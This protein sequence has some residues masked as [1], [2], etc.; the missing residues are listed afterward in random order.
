MFKNFSFF[1]LVILA[2]GIVGYRWVKN[3]TPEKIFQS[4]FCK[5]KLKNSL[6]TMGRNNENHSKFLG[7][8]KPVTYLMLFENNTEL[9]RAGI[10]WQL[11]GCAGG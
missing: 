8:T 9:R 7:F 3:L 5:S 4:S 6:A 1:A 2:T 11:R 10:Y